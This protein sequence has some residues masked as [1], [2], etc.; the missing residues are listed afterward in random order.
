MDLPVT[1]YVDR[2]GHALAYQ[3]IGEGGADVVWFLEIGLHP[4][5]MWTDPHL[6][7]LF[8]RM[9]TFARNVAFQRRGFGLSEPVDHIPTLE[10]QADDVLAVMDAVGMDRATLVGI[11]STCGALALVAARAPERVAGLVLQEPFVEG[12]LRERDG[13]PH[14]WDEPGRDRWVEG[15]RSVYDHW[16]SGEILEMWDPTQDS[17]FNRRLM[18]L[19]ER[20][21]A[22]PAAARAH[23]E[24]LFRIDFSDTL[25]SIQCTTRVLHAAASPV[26]EGVARYVVETIPHASLHILPPTAPGSSLGEAWIPVVDHVEQ[27]ATGVSRP[28]DADRFLGCVLFTDVVDSTVTLARIGDVAYRDVRAAHEHQVRDEVER[29]DGRLVNVVGDGTFS[30]FDG[31]AEAVRCAARICRSAYGLGIEVRSGVHVCSVERSGLD[32]TGMTVHIGARIAAAAGPGEVLVSRTVRDMV[33]GSGLSF[34]DRGDH[35]LKGVPGRWPLYAL[36][37]GDHTTTAAFRKPLNL[38]AIDR[39]I[40][41]TARRAPQVLRAAAGMANARQRRQSRRPG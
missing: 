6:H 36:I 25:P 24:W 28:V 2:D 30:V 16:G 13:L 35:E 11:G 1:R 19:L 39:A 20:C 33:V 15:W 41:R 9:T 8:E 4:D 34:V 38:N 7:Y 31:P 37:D 26:P 3:V 12:V 18:A 40:L 21:S 32:L 17:P 29:A 27:L 14:G 5:L 23:L 22:T 10:Q